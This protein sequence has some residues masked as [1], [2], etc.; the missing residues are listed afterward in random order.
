MSKADLLEQVVDSNGPV[1]TVEV[2]LLSDDLTQY[3]ALLAEEIE[4]DRLD[5]AVLSIDKAE[6]EAVLPDYLLPEEGTDEQEDGRASVDAIWSR[7]F[8][9][10]AAVAKRSGSTFLRIWI[11]FEVGLRNALVTSR[12]HILE[13]DAEA[14]LVAPDLADRDI[15]HTHAI[16]AWSAASDPLAAQEAL[17]KVRWEWLNDNDGWYSFSAREIEVYAAKLVLLHHW[18]RILSER[19]QRSETGSTQT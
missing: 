14:Y 13:L 6:D 8:H 15:D 9:H 18:R 5:L 3:Q 10:A 4:Q 12:A 16:A 1:K 2:L 11:G 7:Y 19:Q 17:D